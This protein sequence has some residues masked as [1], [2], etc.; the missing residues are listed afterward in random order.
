MPS[1]DLD[2]DLQG[3][4]RDHVQ[5]FEQLEILLRL[6]GAP[7]EWWSAQRV[8]DQL[9]TSPA[10]AAEALDALCRRSL[11]ETKPGGQG[12]VFRYS[13]GAGPMNRLVER[14]AQ[15]YAENP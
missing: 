4:V 7:S 5:S 13:S 12:R 1:D 2:L 10:E 3:F 14:L 9:R 8:A 6:R 15:T 11:L